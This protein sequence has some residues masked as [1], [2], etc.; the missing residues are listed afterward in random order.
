MSV[1]SDSIV[2]TKCHYEATLHHQPISLIYEIDGQQLQTGR[3][4]GWCVDCDDIS[5][6]EPL[7]DEVVIKNKIQP[8]IKEAIAKTNVITKLFG[9]AELKIINGEIANLKT[10]LTIA[11]RR[12]SPQRCLRCGSAR[13]KNIKRSLEG[14]IHPHKCGGYLIKNLEKKEEDEIRFFFKHDKIHLNLEGLRLNRQSYRF[15]HTIEEPSEFLINGVIQEVID[16]DDDI[17]SLIKTISETSSVEIDYAE[18]TFFNMSLMTYVILRFSN[19]Q[20]K[21]DLLDQMTEFQI[22]EI[23]HL[24]E[25]DSENLLL[26]NYRDRYKEYFTEFQLMFD[27]KAADSMPEVYLSRRLFENVTGKPSKSH[28]K[29]ILAMSTFMVDHLMKKTSYVSKKINNMVV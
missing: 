1:S 8:L 23:S 5:D 9:N 18:V 22:N 13:V 24:Y 20:N 27:S 4:Y 28:L 12:F 16:G 14:N 21:V 17:E 11:E 10:Q 29:E 2:C 3:V 26:I 19:L 15:Q 7:F 25:E 6:V